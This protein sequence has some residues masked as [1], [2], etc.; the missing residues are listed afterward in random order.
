MK[1]FY[2][3]E[4]C[5]QQFEDFDEA[6]ACEN[7]HLKEF[8]FE[9]DVELRKRWAFNPGDHAPKQIVMMEREEKWNEEEQKYDYTYTCYTYKYSST[10]SDSKTAE[11]TEEYR[12]RREK[13]VLV[14]EVKRKSTKAEREAEQAA[15]E[16]K[17][18]L[19]DYVLN[20]N[21]LELEEDA[22]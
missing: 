14:K 22:V 16:W 5:G 12:L 7:G 3:C 6:Y 1:Q 19:L 18:K 17:Q 15:V 21:K 10:L 8:H 20:N 2:V 9:M 13:K 11:I 4:K